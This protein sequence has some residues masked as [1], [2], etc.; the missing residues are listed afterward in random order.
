MVLS[1]I[2]VPLSVSERTVLVT[3]KFLPHAMLAAESVGAERDV[4][5]FVTSIDAA[6]DVAELYNELPP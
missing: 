3:V 1:L 2:T 5:C 4:E 6:L